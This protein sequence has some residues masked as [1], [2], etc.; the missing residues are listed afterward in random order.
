MQGKYYLY[1]KTPKELLSVGMMA[2]QLY[3]HLAKSKDGEKKTFKIV[4]WL[5]LPVQ[6]VGC[7]MRWDG[8]PENASVVFISAGTNSPVRNVETTEGMQEGF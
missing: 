2:F 5:S 7:R 6:S 4:G 1:Y 3:S 8:S